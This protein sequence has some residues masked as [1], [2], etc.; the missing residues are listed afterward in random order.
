MQNVSVLSIGFLHLRGTVWQD[1]RSTFLIWVKCLSIPYWHYQHACILHQAAGGRWWRWCGP[2][3]FRTLA[4]Q[5][6]ERGESGAGGEIFTIAESGHKQQPHRH[7]LNIINI[8][9]HGPGPRIQERRKTARDG[10]MQRWRMCD[11]WQLGRRSA[12]CV[13]S[14][15][16]APLTLCAFQRQL[17]LHAIEKRPLRTFCGR[18]SCSQC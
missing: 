3:I 13:P 4:S 1:W 7:N 10:E 15:A 14:S 12:R 5:W 17:C 18:K 9:H 2:D 16:S 11:S 6:R 8:F